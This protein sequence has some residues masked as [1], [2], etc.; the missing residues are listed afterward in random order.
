[1][2][3]KDDIRAKSAAAL[4]SIPETEE[5]QSHNVR[6]VTSPG[7]AAFMQPTIDALNERTKAAE[8]LV[9]EY[10]RKI[11]EQPTD[12]P[13]DLLVEAPG[14]KRKL[15]PEE[16]N[17]LKENLK[18]NPLIHPIVVRKLPDD[19]FEIVSGGNRVDAYK[20][21]GRKSIE[22]IV[23]QIDEA[24]I[25][26]VAFF[27]NLLQAPLPDFDKYRGFR[28]LRDGTGLT[29]K[30]MAKES[31]VPESTISMLFAFEDLPSAALDLIA[32]RPSAIG[33]SCASELAK[34]ARGGKTDQVIEAIRLLIEGKFSQKEAI[35][36]ASKSP[37]MG[38]VVR[39]VVR[40]I[41]V[42]AGRLE[43]CQY[44]GKG[45]SLRID[46]KDQDQRA[47]AQERIS[48]LLQDLAD[49]ARN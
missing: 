22:V 33:M 26:R 47:E 6:P 25:D 16:F 4:A 23:K 43:Y 19:R 7:A 17:E 39:D 30:Q 28:E 5:R 12:L 37:R 14:R 15:T 32:Q 34:L 42:R 24:I 49:E 31:G 40:P 48:K 44:M 46:F 10:K 2:T 38:S 36:H 11:D 41:K 45:I 9:I 1:M 29:G 35:A 21:L 27:V 3:R 13:L 8:A 20:A 18:S